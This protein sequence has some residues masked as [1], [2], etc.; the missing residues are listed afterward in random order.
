[1]QEQ[2]ICKRCGKEFEK[3]SRLRQHEKDKHNLERCKKCGKEFTRQKAL[4]NHM[5]FIHRNKKQRGVKRKKYVWDPEREFNKL[6]EEEKNRIR[7]EIEEQANKEKETNKLTEEE[8]K[9]LIK[10]WRELG[11]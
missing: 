4:K 3:V 2:T 1:M 10:E 7:E 9:N 8:R 11:R 5:W 6:S